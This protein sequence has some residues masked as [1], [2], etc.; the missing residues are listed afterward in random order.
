MQEALSP[1]RE[2]PLFFDKEFAVAVAKFDQVVRGGTAA[3]IGL[4]E[5][6]ITGRTGPT[7]D[8]GNRRKQGNGK[9]AA[10]EHFYGK[11]RI[12]SRHKVPTEIKV[13]FETLPIGGAD[14]IYKL[15]Y[16]LVAL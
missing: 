7:V 16:G 1:R 5:V 11:R 10:R 3:L 14:K 8:Y 4:V 2:P 12:P 6:E 9:D 13:L 15:V